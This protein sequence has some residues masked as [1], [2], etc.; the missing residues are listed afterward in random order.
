MEFARRAVVVQVVIALKMQG[1]VLKL[2]RMEHV[3]RGKNVCGDNVRG[4]LRLMH[5]ARWLPT[6]AVRQRRFVSGGLVRNFT[7]EIYVHSKTPTDFV[8]RVRDAVPD[9]AGWLT[10]PTNVQIQI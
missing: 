4:L 1:P 3:I 9:N 2:F 7:R 10:P 6:G 8:R 5:A